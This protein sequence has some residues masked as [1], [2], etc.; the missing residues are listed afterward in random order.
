M[1]SYTPKEVADMFGVSTMTIRRYE[2][3]GITPKRLPSGFR[4]YSEDDV[5]EFK[6]IFDNEN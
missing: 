4:R 5:K 1:K 3:Y 6:K 2:K